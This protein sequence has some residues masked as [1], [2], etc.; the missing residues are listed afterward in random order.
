MAVGILLIS[1]GLYWYFQSGTTTQTPTALSRVTTV[2]RGDITVTV[3]GSGQV[4]ADAQVDLKP[5][6]A[7]DAIEVLSVAVKND[8]FVKKGQVIAVLDNEDARRS[9]AKAE[10]DVRKA[11]IQEKKVATQYPKKTVDDTRERQLQ[12]AALRQSEIA[13]ADAL[14]RL[15]DYTIRAPFDGIVTGLS[16]ESGDTI[17]QTTI[18]ASVITKNMK[19]AVTLNEVDVVKVTVDTPVELSFDALGDSVLTGKITKL[20][21]IGTTTQGVVSYGAEIT[22][23]TQDERLRPA[24]SATANILVEKKEKALVVPAGAISE[25]ESGSFV[26]VQGSSSSDTPTTIR[27]QVETGLSD[28]IMTEIVSGLQEGERVVESAAAG[29]SASSNTT[30]GN[31]VFNMLL[32]GGNNRNGR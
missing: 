27:R 32:R 14:S 26:M 12:D 4:A 23:D 22:L 11:R 20:D 9:V 28:G 13:L 21:T 18:L 17:S 15:E 10:L 31:N 25:N 24:M 2:K 8:Q 7:G 16:V 6:A 29:S 1:G 5:V 3:S 30:G 19:V